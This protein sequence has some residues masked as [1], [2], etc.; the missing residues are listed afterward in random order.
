MHV[1]VGKG[2]E[3]ERER[4]SVGLRKE[5]FESLVDLRQGKCNSGDCWQGVDAC[6][7]QWQ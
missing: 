4:D 5:D 7:G 6:H 2:R 1:G 3:R